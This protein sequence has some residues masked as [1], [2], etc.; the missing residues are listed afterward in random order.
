MAATYLTHT[1][2]ASAPGMGRQIMRSISA[3]IKHLSCLMATYRLRHELAAL[4]DRLLRDIGLDR[5][6][7]RN[8]Y[9]R[10]DGSY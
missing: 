5:D 8:V 3:W 1:V 2:H 6:A 9:V 4:D 7:I 10:K